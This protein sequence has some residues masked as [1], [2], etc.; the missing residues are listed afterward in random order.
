MNSIPS[1][2]IILLSI[3]NLFFLHKGYSQEER[4]TKE[5]LLWHGAL[6]DGPGP[7][8]AEKVSERGSYTNVSQPRM[9]VH[10]PEHSNGMAV[11]VISG[12]GYAH[13]ESGKESAPA[14]EWLQ[15]QGITAFELIYRLPEEGWSGND[16]PFEDGQRAIRLIRHMSAKLGIDPHKIGIIGFSAGGH[17]A[18]MIA[19][20]FDKQFYPPIDEVDRLSARPDFVALLYPVITMLPPF[21]HTHSEKVII[22]KHP[23]ESQQKRYSVELHVNAQTPPTF[24]AQA[25]DDP[26]SNVENSRLMYKALQRFNITSEI[27]L[28][29]A[30][31][32]GWGMGAPG[33]PEQEWPELFKEWA[34]QNKIWY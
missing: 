26:I 11:L 10:Y 30:G 28:F 21:D 5:I 20:Q 32:H 19:T 27:H 7:R 34:K 16:V 1:K 15:S 22:G 14:A 25:L 33:T 17:L 24:L 6:P 2:T 8:G 12:G 3:I 13:I 4:R 23:R 18:G 29:Q 9:I 31:G